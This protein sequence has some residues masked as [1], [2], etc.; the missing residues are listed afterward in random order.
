LV[1]LKPMYIPKVKPTAVAK[2][3]AFSINVNVAHSFK[4]SKS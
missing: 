1:K 3:A 4:T 2:K